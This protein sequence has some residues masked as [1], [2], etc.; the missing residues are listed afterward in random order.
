MKKV[1]KVTLLV[2]ILLLVL[3]ITFT[4]GWRPFIGPKTRPLTQVKF[5]STPAR[6]VRGA[7]LVNNVAG[8]MDCHAPHRWT[9]HDNPIP[10]NMVAAGQDM[11]MLK[12]LPG[13]VVAPNISPDP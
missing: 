4:I 12:G 5:E 6:L 11:S 9:E 10:P 8:C 7:Y 2:L 1:A 13:Q 3:G